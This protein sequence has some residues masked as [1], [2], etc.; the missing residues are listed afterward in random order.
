[1]FAPAGGD[2]GWYYSIT[3]KFLTPNSGWF[4]VFNGGCWWL[5]LFGEGSGCRCWLALHGV[6][7]YSATAGVSKL[8]E[9]GVFAGVGLPTKFA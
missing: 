1:M 5:L 8:Y 4:L 3:G 7:W 6:L 9:F 2:T